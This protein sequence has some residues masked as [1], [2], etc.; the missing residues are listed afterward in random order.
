MANFNRVII[1]GNL[2]RDPE[3]RHTKNRTPVCNIGIAVN[4]VFTNN[5]GDRQEEVTFVDAD[6]FG[7]VAERISQYF[8]K[9]RPI[10]IE[11][12]LRL[13]Q[14]E[15]RDNGAKRSKLKVVVE[16]FQFIDPPQDTAPTDADASAA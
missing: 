13:E 15:D 6:A 2:T 16:Q 1:A 4:R 14:W 9:G 11:G 8:T 5:A 12:R 7:A 10:L 3:L